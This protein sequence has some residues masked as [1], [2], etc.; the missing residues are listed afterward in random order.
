MANTIDRENSLL[1]SFLYADDVGTDKSDTFILDVKI[2]TSKYRKRLAEKINAETENEKLFGYLSVTIE[3]VTKGT[4]FEN[5]WLNILVQTPFP[6]SVSKRIHD[7]LQKEFKVR[8][9]G[10]AR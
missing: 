5:E 9:A 10:G 7:D 4:P 1:A 6:F 3:D 2:F 8:V